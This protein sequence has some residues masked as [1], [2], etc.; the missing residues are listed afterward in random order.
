MG[1]SADSPG[2]HFPPPLFAAFAVL[3]GWWL[4]RRWPMPTPE[5][6]GREVPGWALVALAFALMISGMVF[7][8]IHRTTIRPN[9]AATTLVQRGPYA[10]TRNPLYLSLVT[11]TAGLGFLLRS[12]WIFVLWPFLVLILDRAVIAKEERHLDAAFGEAYA[13]YK[14]RVRRWI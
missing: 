1:H 7:L 10:F 9:K 6:L 2:I 5:G 14:G 12:P 3:L 8:R 13:D 11:A 4:Q